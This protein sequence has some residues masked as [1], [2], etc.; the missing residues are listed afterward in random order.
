MII[1]IAVAVAVP[2]LLRGEKRRKNPPKS[3]EDGLALRNFVL[4]GYFGGCFHL[5]IS[6]LILTRCRTVPCS[7]VPF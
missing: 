7:T 5:S 1:I 3:S 4:A 6:F 2:S